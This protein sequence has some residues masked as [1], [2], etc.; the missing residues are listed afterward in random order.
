M[1]F[2]QQAAG[3]RPKEIKC[4][5]S[6]PALLYGSFSQGALTEG[7]NLQIVETARVFTQ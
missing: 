7:S 2:S 5:A 3:K 6:V 4:K 1:Y